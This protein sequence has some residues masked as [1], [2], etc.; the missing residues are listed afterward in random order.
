LILENE[1]LAKFAV[2]D[3]VKVRVVPVGWYRGRAF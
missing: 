2:R 1:N 3:D